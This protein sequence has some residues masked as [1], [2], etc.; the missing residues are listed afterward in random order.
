MFVDSASCYTAAP[1]GNV[2]EVAFWAV[3]VATLQRPYAGA[4]A[5]PGFYQVSV[6]VTHGALRAVGVPLVRSQPGVGADMKTAYSIGLQPSSPV[7][8]LVSGFVAAYL[9]GT[10]ALDRYVT[11]NSGL[12]AVGGYQ[13][14]NVAAVTASALVPEHPGNKAVAHVLVT[15]A[16][17]TISPD[18]WVNYD[19]P[20][21]LQ[22]AAGTWLVKAVDT[23]PQINP[24]TKPA[25]VATQEV[26]R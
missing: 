23:T 7:Y 20:L 21:T 5:T 14:V 24:H 25:P 11:G 17:E 1:K 16:A 12:S 18:V 15:V 2:G 22:A 13:G 4:G 9:T 19:Y 3:F 6:A 26:P 8:S 10:P